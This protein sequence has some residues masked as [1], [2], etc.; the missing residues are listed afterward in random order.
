[1]IDSFTN[2]A[3]TYENLDWVK[4]DEYTNTVINELNITTGVEHIL[5]IGPG[6]GPVTRKLLS[7][8]QDLRFTAIEPSQ[9]MRD[10]FQQLLGDQIVNVD[11]KDSWQEI[12][13]DDTL[14]TVPVSGFDRCL[15]RNVLH[16]FSS[17]KEIFDKLDLVQRKMNHNGIIVI[18]DGC[19]PFSNTN[20][21]DD[22]DILL[23]QQILL[24]KENRLN[25]VQ[26]LEVVEHFC[27]RY[28]LEA[29][30]QFITKSG[31]S[32]D[33]WLDNDVTVNDETKLKIKNKI[34]NMPEPQQKRFGVQI[35]DDKLYWNFN[36]FIV[37][38]YMP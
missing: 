17:Y 22:N 35:I 7:K 31:I 23:S 32:I 28:Q 30:T 10:K 3:A 26:I 29:T 34:S 8:H 1:M 9:G 21:F 38:I 37:T 4:D 36:H 14:L 27:M 13:D 20:Q 12:E 15:A 18:G 6:T 16:H 2:R 33:N 24:L 11:I 25:S 5:N 19:P